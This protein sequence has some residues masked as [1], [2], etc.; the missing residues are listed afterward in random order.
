ME[1]G[2]PHVL[3]LGGNLGGLP[4]R[5]AGAA[6]H[7]RGFGHTRPDGQPVWT[8]DIREHGAIFVNRQQC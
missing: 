6:L 7:D 4:G 5:S 8:R 3:V 1:R 2:K